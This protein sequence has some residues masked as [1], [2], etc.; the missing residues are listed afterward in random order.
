VS[1]YSQYYP[2]WESSSIL[3]GSSSTILSHDHTFVLPLAVIYLNYHLLSGSHHP[4]LVNITRQ[5]STLAKGLL[6][7]YGSCL[8]IVLPQ[9]YLISYLAFGA[10]HLLMRKL[11]G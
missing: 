4:F 3:G 11:T 8:S 1:N 2:A 6:V 5:W 7:L 9:T 10:T